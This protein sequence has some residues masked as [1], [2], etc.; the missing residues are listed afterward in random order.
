MKPYDVSASIVVYRN[1]PAQVVAAVESVLSSSARVLCTV[2]DNSPTPDLRQ[3][4]LDRGA[5]YLFVGAN[6][7][8]GAGHNRAL[9]ANLGLADYHLMQNPDIC[10]QADVPVTLCRLMDQNPDV[11]QVMPQILYPDG[12]EQRLCKRLPSPID[13]I[14]RRFFGSFGETLFRHRLDSYELHHLDMTVAREVPNLSGCFMFIRTAALQ[15]AGLFDERYFMYMED[16]DLCRRIGQHYK[17]VFYPHVAVT[18][19]YAKASYRDKRL[20]GHHLRSAVRYFSKWG[21]IRDADRLRLN[22]RTDPVDL[23]T[24]EEIADGVL[25]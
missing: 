16:I 25:V 9:R 6:L 22:R 24:H 5:E 4:V 19:G 8:F 17:T 13:L 12:S 3:A 1:D 2:V 15:K 21:W 10:F 20:L 23:H 18:H 14:T 7:G 11:G